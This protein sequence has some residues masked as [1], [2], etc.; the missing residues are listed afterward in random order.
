MEARTQ[1][2]IAAGAGRLPEHQTLART[3]DT[4]DAHLPRELVDLEMRAAL[5]RVAERLP[6]A[7]TRRIYLE[8]RLH[9]AAPAV[10]LVLCV[11]RASRARL[12][13]P[14]AGWLPPALRSHPL[15]TG[16]ARVCSRWGDPTS[17]LHA[18]IY[19]LWLEFDARE[20]PSGTDALVPN[21]FIG[22]IGSRSAPRDEVWLAAQASLELLRSR[23]IAPEIRLAAQHCIR[24]L[25]ATATLAYVGC[26]YP[27]DSEAL[28]LCVAPVDGL[29]VADYL[30]RI[31]WPGSSEA[32]E[33]S[34]LALSSAAAGGAR[35]TLL[36]VDVRDTVQPRIGIEMA[37]QQVPQLRGDLVERHLLDRLC[38][39]DLCTAAKRDALMRWPGYTEEILPHHCWPSIVLRRVSHV[40]LVFEPGRRPLAKAYLS[41]FH[42]QRAPRPRDVRPRARA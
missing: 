22:F 7:L 33:R 38:G 29:A 25:P 40:K 6:A 11:D 9:E 21:V 12:E 37:L 14:P 4:V 10:D 30:R 36:H 42:G 24:S 1:N 2:L 39:L 23:S 41:V 34:L 28:R 26:M 31:T 35:A 16:V 32:L 5:Q 13:G 15:W 18:R 20:R 27:R 17:A 3:L 19:D 8:C